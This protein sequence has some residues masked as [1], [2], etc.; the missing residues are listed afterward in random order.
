MITLKKIK[1]L[2]IA[3][4]QFD[5]LK[6][7]KKPLDYS[8]WVQYIN[9]NP[10]IFIWY[11]DTPDGIDA[12]QNIDKIPD[13]FKECTMAL[14]NKVRCFTDF[15]KKKNIYNMSFGCSKNNNETVAISFNKV[16]TIKDLK[17]CLDMANYLD[18]Y[19][20]HNG[21]TII[22]EKIIESLE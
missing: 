22:D 19:L 12:K 4:N 17:L 5:F 13:K 20:L 7:I 8:K 16:P 10:D 1:D 21:K 15:N 9:N 18:A 14:L 6:D 3:K 11:E 2:D